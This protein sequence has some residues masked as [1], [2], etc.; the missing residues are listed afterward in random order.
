MMEGR[1]FEGGPGRTGPVKRD[2]WGQTRHV[3]QRPLTRI[4]TIE[5]IT[6]SVE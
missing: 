3:S 4:A 5:T 2:A 1:V 6:N